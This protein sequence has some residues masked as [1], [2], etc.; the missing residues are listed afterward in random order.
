[1]EPT[2]LHHCEVGQNSF[3]GPFCDVQAGVVIGNSSHI[4]S[5]TYIC[6][7]AR[8]GDQCFIGHGVKLLDDLYYR[9]RSSATGRSQH[10]TRGAIKIGDRVAIGSG[11]SIHPA[12]VIC[13]D[14]II[15]AGAVVMESINEPGVFAGIPAKRI[16]SESQQKQRGYFPIPSRRTALLLA[17]ASLAALALHREEVREST[18]KWISRA[19]DSIRAVASAES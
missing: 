1:M 14:T 2:S 18:S 13:S 6:A 19:W 5:H 15:E 12:V 17:G 11:T 8:I 16:S 9:C 3:I 4:H 10:G 7:D